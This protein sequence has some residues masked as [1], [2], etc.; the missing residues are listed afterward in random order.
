MIFGN[1]LC[2]FLL[3]ICKC[4]LI[5]FCI[6]YKYFVLGFIKILRFGCYGDEEG[7]LSGG[8]LYEKFK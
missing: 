2:N 1:R 3:F 6:F 5:L 4:G 8:G 7:I